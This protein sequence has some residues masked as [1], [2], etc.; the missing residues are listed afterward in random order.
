MQRQG[1]NK[2]IIMSEC[3]EH[4]QKGCR[5][6]YGRIWYKGK[7]ELAHRLAYC[8]AKDATL[9]AIKGK[10]V[11]HTCDNPRCINPEHLLIGTH[12]DN[13]DDRMRRGRHVSH[14][15]VKHGRAKLTEEDVKFI[16]ENYVRYSKEFG[17]VALGCKFGV[18][19]QTIF[20]VVRGVSWKHV[21][22]SPCTQ[23]SG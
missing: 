2:E 1:A 22:D 16:R 15:G 5:K 6:G 4:T 14:Q 3:V 7:P 13:V 10:V 23:V 11:R 9:A 8:K 12:Q 19:V 21:E 18:S 17:T 20:K